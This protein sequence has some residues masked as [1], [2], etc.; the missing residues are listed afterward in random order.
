MERIENVDL[1]LFEFDFDVTFMV[2]FLNAD[3]QVY[4]RFGGRD[5]KDPENRQSLAGLRYAM[6]A[7][8]DAHR[9]GTVSQALQKRGPARDFWNRQVTVDFAEIGCVHCHQVKQLIHEDLREKGQWSRDLIWSYPLPDNLGLILDVDRGDVVERVVPNSP[10]AEIGLKSGDV[11]EELG[12]L[13]VHSFAD[14]QF[15][16]DRAPN[17]GSLPIVWKSGE[18]LRTGELV[19][20]KGWRRTDISWRSSMS[21]MVATAPV[22]GKDLTAEERDDHNLTPKQLAFWQKSQVAF[23]ARSAGIRAGDLVVGFDGLSLEMDAYQFQDYVRSNYA[24][25]DSV[26]V[27]VLREGKRLSLPL[28]LK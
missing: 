5:A 16:L 10:A 25:G 1:S 11:V 4:G 24:A 2:F 28:T 14:A 9:Q 17:S 19:L 15:A 6:R 18:Q 23:V 21:A 22:Y 20:V 3:E 8:L 13:P 26:T 27:E 7:A 12:G